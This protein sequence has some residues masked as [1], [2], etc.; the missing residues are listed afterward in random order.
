MLATAVATTG[1]AALATALTA[2]WPGDGPVDPAAALTS[3]CL[4]LA[5]LLVG[6]VGV[7]LLTATLDLARAVH[8]PAPAPVPAAEGPRARAVR[9]ASTL[10]VVV[11]SALAPATAATAATAASPT[12]IS[13]PA[14]AAV[15]G[16]AETPEVGVPQAVTPNDD[17]VGIPVPGWTPTPPPP[18]AAPPDPGAVAL[19]AA[20]PRSTPDPS[21]P[22]VVHRGDTLWSIAAR[23]LG[24]DATTTDVAAEWPR[25]YAANREL[26]GDDPDLIRPGQE[27]VVPTDEGHHR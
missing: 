4:L 18:V 26:I 7:V 24:A 14:T 23:H 10:L 19:V 8:H 15:T 13:A 2:T 27:L 12:A 1:A 25:W 20:A 6:G 3:V 22:V 16:S 21:E 11:A 9:V 5:S 17:D